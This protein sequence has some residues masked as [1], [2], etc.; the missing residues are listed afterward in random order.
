VVLAGGR[1][2]VCVVGCGAVVS[3]LIESTPEQDTYQTPFG[4]LVVYKTGRDA[5]LSKMT[6]EEPLPVPIRLKRKYRMSQ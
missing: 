2:G 5:G 6:W 3:D 4:L 1:S